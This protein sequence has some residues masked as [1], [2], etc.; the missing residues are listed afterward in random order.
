M[1]LD[2]TKETV[3]VNQ[4]IG[5][6]LE[7]IMVEGDMIVPD[8]KPDILNTISS[9]GNI[10]IYKKE[11]MDGKIRIDGTINVYIMYLADNENSNVRALNTNLDFTK[12]I[13]MDNCNQDMNI[14]D[15]MSIKAIECKVINGRKINIK[16]IIDANIKVYSNSNIQIINEIN[17]MNELQTLENMLEINSLVGNGENRV[18][19]KDTIIIDNIDDLAEI[20][21]V[22]IN[23]V[24]K[25]TKVSYNKVLAKADAEVKIMYL[26]ED[27]RI[28]TV[29]NRIPVMGFI[30]MP[31]VT[32]DNI[33]N[34]K[35]KLKNLLVKPNN[36]EEHS[37]Y[38]E[39]ELELSCFV[40]EKKNIK[41]IQDLYSPVENLNFNKK[42]ITTR[43]YKDKASDLCV[44]KEK[45]PAEN[46]EDNK[47]LDM[48]VGVNILSQNIGN[49]R[50]NYEAEAQIQYTYLTGNSNKIDVKSVNIAFNFSM[51]N[52]S[53]TMDSMVETNIEVADTTCVVLPDFNIETK[54]N[55]EFNIEIYKNE[56]LNIIDEINQEED[57]EVE[58]YSMVIYYVKPKDT[59]WKIAKQFK[60]TVND[61]VRVNGI[62]N[63]D[64]LNVGMQLFIP[65]YSNVMLKNA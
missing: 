53:I 34:T 65:K 14:D 42:T 38:I 59:L 2:T 26:T 6:K 37:I 18:Y 49:G 46:I 39:A 45:I 41:I 36:V 52:Q 62:E 47:I 17:N 16:A 50:I 48:Q 30:D 20:L 7:S 55:L 13:D 5:Q 31:N 15:D 61:I 56:V 35:Y 23:V 63:P 25:E 10:C 33:C 44:L 40:Y 64:K 51:E 9:S 60:S 43:C 32:D 12:V 3:C 57:G 8:I 4:I 11:V 27:D 24:N 21:R 22:N 1:I 58:T 28:N 29:T 54:I 19:A